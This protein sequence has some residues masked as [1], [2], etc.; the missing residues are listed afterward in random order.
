MVQE[1]GGDTQA[2]EIIGVLETVKAYFIKAAIMEHRDAMRCRF[3]LL[4]EEMAEA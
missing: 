2:A 3:W 1:Y 4:A